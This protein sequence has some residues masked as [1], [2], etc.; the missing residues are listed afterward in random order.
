[1]VVMKSFLDGLAENLYFS[2]I[3][4]GFLYSKMLNIS[5][6]VGYNFIFAV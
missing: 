6:H 1:M 4:F 3:D 2:K 5:L